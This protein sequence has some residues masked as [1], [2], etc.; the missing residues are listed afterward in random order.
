MGS[1]AVPGKSG[2]G[3]PLGQVA[4]AVGSGQ[5]RLHGVSEGPEAGV[6]VAGAGGWRHLVSCQGLKPELVSRSRGRRGSEGRRS[7]AASAA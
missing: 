2:R 5:H 6:W 1:Q 4:M 7:P 3:L